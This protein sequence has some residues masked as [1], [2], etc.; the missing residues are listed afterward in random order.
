MTELGWAC[1]W[2]GWILMCNGTRRGKCRS[3]QTE[4]QFWRGSCFCC[5]EELVLL[6]Y[7]S[8]LSQSFCLSILP[9]PSPFS[10]HFCQANSPSLTN[11]QSTPNSQSRKVWQTC[12]SFETHESN[13]CAFW[14]DAN[15]Q[16]KCYTPYSAYMSSQLS[17]ITVTDTRDWI[18]PSHTWSTDSFAL[19]TPGYGSPEFIFNILHTIKDF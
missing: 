10:L 11:Y 1:K 7:L 18:C 19:L 4:L 8:Q 3:A 9:H 15:A 6:C 2:P 16:G 14:T 5:I 17:W 12:A 13:L